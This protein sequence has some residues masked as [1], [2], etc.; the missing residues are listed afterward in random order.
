[1]RVAVAQ[2]ASSTDPAV[3]LGLVRESAH[4]A[5]DA[6]ARLVVFPEATMASFATASATVA[7]PLDGQWADGVRTIALDAGIAVVVG[8]FESRPGERRPFN[9]LLATG[10]G[11]REAAYRKIHLFDAW[12]FRESDHIAPGDEPVTIALDGLVFGLAT[13]YDVRFP[14]LFQHYGGLGAH[15]VLV[16]AS[17][18]N[19]EGK[20]DQ[21]QTLCRARAMDSTCYA[22]AAAQADPA[23][24]GHPVKLGAP[25]GVGHSVVV[26]PLGRVLAE[27]G[28]AP[29]LLVVDL[30]I[31]AVSD[32]RGRVPVLRNARFGLVPPGV[33]EA[34]PW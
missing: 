2:I 15:A 21:W 28:P 4:R 14:A 32:A 9:T 10:P 24:A 6:G 13:C 3:N 8:L 34:V 25:T 17:W 33:S 5:A 31:G 29:A 27:A 11:V 30:D 1:M 20:A 18:A 7:Q 16:P 19:G 12:G 26:D 22:V 23:T